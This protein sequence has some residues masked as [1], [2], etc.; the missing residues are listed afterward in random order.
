MTLKTDRRTFIKGSLTFVPAALLGA[1]RLTGLLAKD[2]G[3]AAD[4]GLGT[5]DLGR[6]NI[7]EVGA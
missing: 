6:L 2:A 7:K 1:D 5:T 3:G 4:F